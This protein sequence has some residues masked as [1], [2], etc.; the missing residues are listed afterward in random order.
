MMSKETAPGAA[1]SG[2]KAWSREVE[3]VTEPNPR[4]LAKSE[5]H[6]DSRKM[7][8]GSPTTIIADDGR[9]VSTIVALKRPAEDQFV[10]DIE[11]YYSLEYEGSLREERTVF[12]TLAEAVAFI[13]R[14][15]GLRFDQ[16]YI[17]GQNGKPIQNRR[18]R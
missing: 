2:R 4:Y 13:T 7:L 11:V 8:F 1:E 9:R 5:H 16:M 14:E 10:V 3:Q 12:A 18:T 15:T 6:L 17:R